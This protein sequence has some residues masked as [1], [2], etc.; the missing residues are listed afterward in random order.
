MQ[1]APPGALNQQAYAK[2][3]K[4]TRIACLK[5]VLTEDTSLP[6]EGDC[7][8]TISLPLDHLSH[9]ADV[10]AIRDF[11]HLVTKQATAPSKGN[12]LLVN[13]SIIHAA[14]ESWGRP[15]GIKHA[16]APYVKAWKNLPSPIE[17]NTRNDRSPLA[18]GQ[19]RKMW[20]C[21]RILCA[22]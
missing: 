12:A 14:W 11:C 5:E 4:D 8:G 17:P 19:Y 16:L 6:F 1:W 22:S 15:L 18:P 2:A 7:P 10:D 20:H 9:Q 13:M 21:I 3:D